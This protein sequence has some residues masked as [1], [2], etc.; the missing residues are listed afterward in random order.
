MAKA[1][2]SEKK[3][4][5]YGLG[6]P[7]YTHS[8]PPSGAIPTW[9]SPAPGGV[10]ASA[11]P[12]AAEVLPQPAPEIAQLSSDRS[13]LHERGARI[14]RVMQVEYMKRHWGDEFEGVI[15]E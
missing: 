2:Y 5:H 7:Y 1:I 13:G 4:R 6:F 11:L 10:R 14:V 9:C 3:H 12:P 15:E 8:P